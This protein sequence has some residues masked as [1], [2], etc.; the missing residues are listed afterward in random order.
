MHAFHATLNDKNQVDSLLGGV[1]PDYLSPESRF[2]KAFYVS[3]EA[4]TALAELRYHGADPTHIIRY[5]MD[6]SAMRILDLTRARVAKKYHYEGGPIT[7]YTRA[8]GAAALGYG[9]NVIRFFS[10]NAVGEINHAI[11]DN[12][13]QILRPDMVVQVKK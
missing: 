7:P 4:E 8:I 13:S 2:G 11:L 5:S 3:D 12:F 6:P 9:F 10:E 1:D